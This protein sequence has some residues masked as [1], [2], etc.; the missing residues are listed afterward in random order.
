MLN[1]VKHPVNYAWWQ[2]VRLIGH[3]TAFSMTFY[4][5]ITK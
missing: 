4:V 5:A 1:A 3:F 2:P